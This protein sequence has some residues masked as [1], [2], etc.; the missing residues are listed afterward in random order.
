MILYDILAEPIPLSV[1][2][3]AFAF[4]WLGH[5][6]RMREKDKEIQFLKEDI[7]LLRNHLGFVRNDKLK[8]NNEY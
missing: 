1:M 5:V 2:L 3:L 8:E 7:T 4:L 6:S